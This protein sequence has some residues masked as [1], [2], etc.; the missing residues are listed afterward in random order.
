MDISVIIPVYNDPT[1]IE[2]TLQ[3]LT[4]Q[5]YSSSDYEVIVV[6]NNS[7]DET[8]DIIKQYVN[9]YPN[10]VTIEYETEIQGSYAARNTGIRNS[11]GEILVFLD[12]N[13][14]VSEKA[15][16]LI[17]DEIHNSNCDYMGLD[18]SVEIPP[19]ERGIIAE[20]N[21]ARAFPIE[22]YLKHHN[23]APTCGL[24]VKRSVIEEVGYFDQ[25]M[26]S[27]GDSKFGKRVAEAG[28]T[29]CFSSRVE[30]VH[31]ARTTFSEIISKGI[32]LGEGRAQFRE[33]NG[34]RLLHVKDVLPPN[35][36][37]YWKRIGGKEP[38]TR[39]AIFY[40]L[41]SIMKVCK[42]VGIMKES[43]NIQAN[44]Q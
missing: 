33:Y 16:E 36:T 15:I 29:Q 28:Y 4:T 10:I 6:D 26:T 11:S 9:Q 5:S 8:P 21:K 7:S 18:V 24:A 39:F 23:F 44:R 27:S 20:Y 3:S 2:N 37:M 1:G 22:F 42:L 43:F 38:V 14:T 35:P 25:R 30:F 31:P 13:V 12:S 41:E 40:I 19:S 32:R 17:V 34:D